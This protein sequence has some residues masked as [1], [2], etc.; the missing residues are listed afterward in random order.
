MNFK[1]FLPFICLIFSLQ[2][3]AQETSDSTEVYYPNRYKQSDP[4]VLY[5]SQSLSKTIPFGNSSL[6]D[7]NSLYSY[8]IFEMDFF[9]LSMLTVG[10]YFEIGYGEVKDGSTEKLGL[11]T[12]TRFSSFG[13]QLGYYHAFNR[14]WNWTLKGG[15]AALGYRSHAYTS[16][17]FSEG[18]TSYKLDAQIAY[19]LG[20]TFAFYFKV[21]PAYD[22]LKIKATPDIQDYLNH[23]FKMNIG[24]G[25]RIHLHNPDD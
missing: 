5:F 21:A 7:Y 13:L 3:S 4:E 19:R 22:K 10:T 15:I 6:Q 12:A 11:I 2:L 9:A 1:Y 18:G 20:P 8:S 25:F 24:L 16:D 17:N 14:R 23:H